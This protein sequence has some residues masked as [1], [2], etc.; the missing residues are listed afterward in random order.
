MNKIRMNSKEI[1]RFE[2][3]DGVKKTIES[4]III[5]PGWGERG[6]FAG[7]DPTLLGFFSNAPNLVVWF[8]PGP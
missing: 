3:R 4:V 5:I 7:G 2:L 6:G 8:Y 1:M